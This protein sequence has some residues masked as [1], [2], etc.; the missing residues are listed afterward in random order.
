MVHRSYEALAGGLV[1]AT[2]AQGVRLL[3]FQQRPVASVVLSVS[4]RL[5][6]DPYLL[7]ARRGLFSPPYTPKS[8][9][10]RQPPAGAAEPGRLPFG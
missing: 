9:A 10:C 6:V 1:E 2:H 5:S 8:P 7:P 4:K 3:V